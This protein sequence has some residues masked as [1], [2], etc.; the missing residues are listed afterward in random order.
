MTAADKALAEYL[1]R[2]REECRPW[3]RL[4]FSIGMLTLSFRCQCACP[5]CGVRSFLKGGAD[6]KELTAGEV[7]ALLDDF[8]SLGVKFVNFFGGEPLLDPRLPDY[9]R[10]AALLG[11][12]PVLDTNGLLLDEKTVRG[13][14]EAGLFEISVSLDSPDPATHDRFR[15][16]PGLFEK[17]LAG[18]EHCRRHGLKATMTPFVTKENLR[19]GD[20]RK[21][22]TLAKGLGASVRLSTPIHSGQLKGREEALLSPDDL[23]LVRDLLEDGRVYWEVYDVDNAAKPF[24]CDAGTSLFFVS[25]YG[26]VQPC[27]F[28]G[29]RFGSVRQEPLA[30]IL[31]R[32]MR[33]RLIG[34]IGGGDCPMND[35]SFRKANDAS[36]VTGDFAVQAESSAEAARWD[37]RARVYGSCA[38]P[39]FGMNDALVAGKVS[40]AGLSVLDAGCGTGRFS[41]RIAGKTR[42]VLLCDVS[43]A[44]LAAAR[45]RLEGRANAA[46]RQADLSRPGLDL[47]RK[48]DVVVAMG[49]LRHL[50]DPEQ[51]LRNLKAALKTGGTLLAV[52]AIEAGVDG[53]AAAFHRRV[54]DKHGLRAWREA[55]LRE[56][57]ASLMGALLGGPMM[58]V[59]DVAREWRPLL[60][61]AEIGRI[62]DVFVLLRWV[63]RRGSVP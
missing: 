50:N 36:L 30:A 8:S 3:P 23:R 55:F 53:A 4:N 13:L 34:G 62:N 33:S 57:G 29:V 17:A 51:A 22:I 52:D 9:V 60:P 59:E 7:R 56:P 41:S 5:H 46:F 18:L 14:K 42:D 35:G 10:H 45:R 6:G 11:L 28:C 20:L 32:M 37:E 31:K 43:P 63:K 27:C 48:V 15:G 25:P 21:L 58:T 12:K 49:L 40:F 39:V 1:R 47:G 44:M 2:R 19:N 16:V 26:D 61:G 24:H 38:D 54:I